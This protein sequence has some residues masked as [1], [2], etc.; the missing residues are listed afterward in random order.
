MHDMLRPRGSG[1]ILTRTSSWDSV[2]A[3]GWSEAK[4]PRWT[5]WQES[6][7]LP[8]PLEQGARLSMTLGRSCRVP[9]F[10]LAPDSFWVR[11]VPDARPLC[12]FWKQ[13]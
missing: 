12:P 9:P 1:L 5:A 10:S 6:R 2:K 7:R 4:E 13:L 3:P 8:G 11:M